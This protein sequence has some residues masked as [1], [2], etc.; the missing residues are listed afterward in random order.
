M[1]KHRIS[2]LFLYKHR[3][4][5]GFGLLGLVFIA[6]IF[7]IP[8]LSPNGLSEAEMQSAVDSMSINRESIF[9]GEIVDL[10]YHALQKASIT[11]FGLS[12]YAIKLPSIVIGFFLGSLLI[13]LLNRW[14]KNNVALIS[15]ILTVVSAPFLYLVGT[16]TPLIMLV[17]W[18]TLLLWLGSKIQGVK[19]PRASF[20]F[21]FAL[22]LFVSIFTPYMLYLAAFIFIYAI[23]HPHL[24]FTI[25]TLPTIPFVLAVILA[26]SGFA[27]IGYN[28]F[29]VPET[30]TA[31]L[32][33]PGFEFK[34]FLNNLKTGFLPFFSWTGSVTST[35]LSPM[36]GLASVALAVTGLI[37][38]TK[39]FFASRNS[40]ASLFII[41]TVLLTGINP[42][43]AI[44]IILPF[45]I[46]TAHGVRYILEKWYGLF[47]ENPYA[48]IFAIFPVGLLLGILLASSTFH[49][50]F[51]YRYNP[52]VANEFQNDLSLIYENVEPDTTLLVAGGTL[53]YDFYHILE[54]TA[55]FK[56][57]TAPEGSEKAI[58]TLGKWPEKLDDYDLYRIITSPKS[59]NSDRIYIY[60]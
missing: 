55:G 47:P 19:K 8:L 6:L 10:P 41:F 44:L 29:K 39:G 4:A 60:K 38:T 40:I 1:K 59:T 33:A 42:D 45:A 36:L 23:I 51:G 53:D 3:W 58:A 52:A 49:Y 13:L 46:L 12:A 27:F 5:L 43:C 35:L 32:F 17:L 7:L 11:I 25:K 34:D 31:L 54:N 57:K 16:G 21:L 48:R 18:P 24:R 56:V 28:I 50:I 9:A 2:S 14:F 37:S 15:S 26:L 30:L 20:C 22:A